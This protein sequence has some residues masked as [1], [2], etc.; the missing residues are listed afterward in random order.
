[1]YGVKNVLLQAAALNRTEWPFALHL[2][3]VFGIIAS[4]QFFFSKD[5]A[6]VGGPWQILNWISDLDQKH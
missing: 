6:C 3:A 2:L 5:G 1:M 4:H